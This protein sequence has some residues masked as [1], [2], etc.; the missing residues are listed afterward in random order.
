ML[1]LSDVYLI[2][3][4]LGLIAEYAQFDLLL[5]T[6]TEEENSVNCVFCMY[7][8]IHYL[9]SGLTSPQKCYKY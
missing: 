6:N 3:S 1:W 9:C 5:L 4:C 2:S 8:T 7:K